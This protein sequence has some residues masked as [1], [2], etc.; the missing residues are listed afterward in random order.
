MR[1]IDLKVHRTKLGMIRN[2]LLI[3]YGAFLFLW[4]FSFVMGFLILNRIEGLQQEIKEAQKG[5]TCILLIKPEERTK[6]KIVNCIDN[7][8]NDNGVKF[9]FKEPDQDT[10]FKTEPEPNNLQLQQPLQIQQSPVYQPLPSVEVP[11]ET[12]P[13]K[14]DVQVT[15]KKI[16]K[17]IGFEYEGDDF[18]QVPTEDLEACEL[19]N[20]CP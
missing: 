7:N 13:I 17:G 16:I 10:S 14:V 18:I 3:I 15:P 19:T 11:E 2:R 8:K 1:N 9:D 5:N 20:N 6:Q 4:V 12:P